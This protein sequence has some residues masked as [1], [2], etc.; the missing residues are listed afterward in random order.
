MNGYA[1]HVSPAATA[2]HR[3]IN[4]A[5]VRYLGQHTDA[6]EAENGR[7]EL[8]R[9][10]PTLESALTNAGDLAAYAAKAHPEQRGADLVLTYVINDV[11][12]P[13]PADAVYYPE[14][15]R[16]QYRPAAASGDAAARTSR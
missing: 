15:L 1:S 9:F 10:L 11:K 13:T 2:V 6:Q 16:L 4:P 3:S 5:H 7:K 8:A 14:P 12:H